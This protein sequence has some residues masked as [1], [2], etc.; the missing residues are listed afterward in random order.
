MRAEFVDGEGFTYGV[1]LTEL[2]QEI[3][4]QR[5]LNTVNF[6]VPI[7]GLP[8]H[9]LIADTTSHQQGATT[10]TANGVGQLQDFFGDNRHAATV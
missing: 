1:D 9:Q 4:E 3:S 5:R 10:G 7:L 8:A 2:R 6:Q